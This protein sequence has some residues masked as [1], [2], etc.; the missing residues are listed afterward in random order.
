MFKKVLLFNL[1]LLSVNLTFAQSISHD[2]FLGTWI[3]KDSA[4]EI[5]IVKEGELLFVIEFIRI[6]HE[7]FFSGDGERA[8]FQEWGK[9]PPGTSGLQLG[10]DKKTI[11][12]FGVSENAEWALSYVFYKKP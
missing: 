11:L 3:M 1:L 10:D 2:A 4:N 9:G 6:K 5:K 12:F 8:L 7:L